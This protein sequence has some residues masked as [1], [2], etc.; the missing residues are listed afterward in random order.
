MKQQKKTGTALPSKYY[1]LKNSMRELNHLYTEKLVK[2]F[3][4][5]SPRK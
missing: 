1:L 4:V 5:G 3:L 2:D